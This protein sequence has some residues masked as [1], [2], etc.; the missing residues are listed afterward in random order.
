MT[1]PVHMC[2]VM[3][4][5]LD[6]R[7]PMPKHLAFHEPHDWWYTSWGG[8]H[9]LYDGWQPSD[10]T[11]GFDTIERWVKQWRC[12][13]WRPKMAATKTDLIVWF[14]QGVEDGYQRMIVWCDTF[15]YDDYPE[16]SDRTGQLL[17][18]YVDAKKA[19][20]MT[21]LMEVY[22]LTAD[23]DAQMSESRAFHY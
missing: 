2:L 21:Q 12:P 6:G 4:M 19:N 1:L 23:M 5:R 22:D 10:P 8:G 13:G 14:R 20:P 7:N 9:Q 11:L 18:D 16:Y 17:R 3:E 15:D